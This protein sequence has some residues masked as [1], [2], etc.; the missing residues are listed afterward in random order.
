MHINTLPGVRHDRYHITE[1]D[2]LKKLALEEY[3]SK[4]N[5]I[6]RMRMSSA[7]ANFNAP[8]KAM[9]APVSLTICCKRCGASATSA[10]ISMVSAVPAGFVIARDE[11]L[12]P[13]IPSTPG[14]AQQ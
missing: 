8:P 13:S 3:G 7:G 6:I 11:V 10:N 14:L 4:A 1:I 5:A 12:A 2:H 9:Q